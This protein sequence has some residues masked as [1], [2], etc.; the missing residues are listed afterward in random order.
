MI[1]K[2]G[3]KGT[4]LEALLRD[5]YKGS[6]KPEEVI[7]FGDG[8]NDVSMF[9]V[10]GMSVAMGNAMNEELKRVATWRAGWTNDDGAVGRFLEAVF[11]PETAGL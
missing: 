7:A 9:K 6:I 2:G 3:N 5:Y 4:G 1:P 10:A 11:W 8:E